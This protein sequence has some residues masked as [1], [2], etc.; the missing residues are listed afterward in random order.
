MERDVKIKLSVGL[1]AIVVIHAVLLA[2][3]FTGLHHTGSQSNRPLLDSLVGPQYP[4]QPQF[5][6]PQISAPTGYENTNPALNEIKKQAGRPCVNCQ[7]QIVYPLSVPQ[8]HYIVPTPDRIMPYAPS[9]STIVPSIPAPHVTVAPVV[10]APRYQLAL[11]VD[12]SP[13]GQQLLNWFNN[14]P[15]LR[16]LRAK[17]DFQTYTPSN[18][19]Y[20]TRYASI[21]PVDQF[22]ALLFLK[23]DGGHIHATGGKMLPST[24]SQL[25]ADLEASFRLAESVERAPGP[26]Q[27]GAMRERGYNWDAAMQHNQLNFTPLLQS[28]CPPGGF[29]PPNGD[30]QPLLPSMFDGAQDKNAMLWASGTEIATVALIGLAALL[31]VV[32]VIKRM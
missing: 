28:D 25:Y 10:S 5:T 22:P 9:G 7:P 14:D 2:A 31:V 18:S 24:A 11:F 1:I 29:C 20:R 3:V 26:V 19:L 12:S 23:P 17:V 27:S 30:R 21:V 15:Q 4:L 6:Q 32:I 16:T 8:P 13:A